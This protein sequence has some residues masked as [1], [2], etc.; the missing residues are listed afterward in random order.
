M[1]SGLRTAADWLEG[2]KVEN[3][4]YKALRG[5]EGVKEAE[6][7]V[8]GLNLKVAIANSTGAAKQLI[9]KIQSGE[10]TYH[11]VEVMACPGGC[12]NGGGQPIVSSTVRNWTDIRVARAKALYDEDAAKTLRKSHENPEIKAIYDEYLGKPN[13]HKSHELLHT[14]YEKRDLYID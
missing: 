1:L 2:R 8:G 3:V 4:E 11:F 14:S 13:G 12:V 9:K 7:T 6:V 5:I 10:A